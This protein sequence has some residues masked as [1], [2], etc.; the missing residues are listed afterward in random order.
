MRHFYNDTGD[1]AGWLI[2]LPLAQAG[3]GAVLVLRGQSLP[4]Y[5]L[6][7]VGFAAF[8]ALL[9]LWRAE[10]P[11]PVKGVVTI[12]ILTE[13]LLLGAIGDGLGG[14][15][16]REGVGAALAASGQPGGGDVNPVGRPV[17]QV[18]IHPA[19]D[20]DRRNADALAREIERRLP[21]TDIRL[22]AD[23]RMANA[24][25]RRLALAWSTGPEGAARW[26]GTIQVF[27]DD[28]AAGIDM[29]A[30]IIGQRV[31]RDGRCR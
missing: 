26:C 18:D 30:R 11:T 17:A 2:A 1:R 19:A 16:V 27:G 7:I 22:Q 5:W 24:P 20:Q 23:L 31:G 13:L 6:A 14:R 9:L 4:F 29:L 15:R 3:G 25:V 21:D 28:T 10:A 8:G 12:G